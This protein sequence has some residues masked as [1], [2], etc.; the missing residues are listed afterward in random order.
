MATIFEYTC[1]RCSDKREILVKSF[2]LGPLPPT[3]DNPGAH[4]GWKEKLQW[5]ESNTKMYVCDSCWLWLSVPTSINLESWESWKALDLESYSPFTKYP[6]LIGIVSRIDRA[7][8]ETPGQPIDLGALSCPY[9]A[10]QF[11]VGRDFQPK[12]TQCGSTEIAFSVC[13][14]ASVGGVWPPIV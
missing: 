6:F 4:K 8:K 10:A 3:P 5:L 1:R 9:C 13:G 2:S 14:I 11:S 7:L 12:C